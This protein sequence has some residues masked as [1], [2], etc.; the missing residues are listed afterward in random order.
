MR[1]KYFPNALLS[2]ALNTD[3]SNYLWL[4]HQY[5]PGNCQ[6]TTLILVGRTIIWNT[7]LGDQDGWS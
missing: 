4:E 1:E 5:N 2:E 6:E 7:T 3:L